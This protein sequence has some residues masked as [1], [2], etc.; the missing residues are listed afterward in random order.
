MGDVKIK[1]GNVRSEQK[2]RDGAHMMI[3]MDAHF[4][5]MREVSSCLGPLMKVS[6]IKR[7]KIEMPRLR[8]PFFSRDRMV[9]VFAYIGLEEVITVIEPDDKKF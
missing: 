1:A 9:V 7:I 6:R 5:L 4:T 8:V 2:S 3:M